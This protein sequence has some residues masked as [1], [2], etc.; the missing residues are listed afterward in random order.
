MPFVVDKDIKKGAFIP[1]IN[2]KNVAQKRGLIETLENISEK[3]FLGPAARITGIKPAVESTGTL[4]TKTGQRI[5]EAVG[6]A[7]LPKEQKEAVLQYISQGQKQAKEIFPTTMEKS[8]SS[9]QL[10]QVLGETLKSAIDIIKMHPSTYKATA[11]SKPL[12]MGTTSSQLKF[13]GL[14]GTIGIMEDA[15]NSFIEGKELNKETLKNA[16]SKGFENAVTAFILGYFGENALNHFIKRKGALVEKVLQPKT[17]AVAKDIYWGNELIGDKIVAEN[18]KGS[19]DKL[20]TQ[21]KEKMNKYGQE[22]SITLSKPNYAKTYVAKNEIINNPA[23]KEILEDKFVT[24]AEKTAVKGVLK[25]I[26]NRISVKTANELKKRFA[27][28]V[29]DSYWNSL[30]PRETFKGDFYRKL[31]HSV[32]TVVNEKVPEIKNIND[33]WHIAKEVSQLSSTRQAIARKEKG[34]FEQVDIGN[35]LAYPIRKV[36]SSPTLNTYQA[37]LYNRIATMGNNKSVQNAL[38]YLILQI[39]NE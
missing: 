23:I 35:I 38:K 3:Y 1:D 36:F 33:K 31:A 24:D 7:T 12:K 37:N 2:Q 39:Q 28:K 30:D 19:Y 26:P 13:S 15:A 8:T 34:M 9:K 27:D 14:A 22:I 11:F 18:Y 21:G 16:G 29:P 20:L 32:R 4:I 5:G 25:E 10:E 6:Y 17:S